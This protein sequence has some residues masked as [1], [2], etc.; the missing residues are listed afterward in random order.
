MRAG[1]QIAVLDK[2]DGL[3]HPFQRHEDAARPAQEDRNARH[4][5]QNE[6]AEHRAKRNL[7]GAFEGRLE[8]PD[9]EHADTL[10]AAIDDR[11]VGRDVPVIDDESARQPDLALL[12]HRLAHDRRDARA[13]RAAAFEQADIGAHA[14]IV[15]KQ[16]RGALASFRQTRLAVNEVVDRIDEFQVAIE[17][18]AA[19]QDPGTAAEIDRCRRMDNHAA[20]LA[21]ALGRH[22]VAGRDQIERGLPGKLRRDRAQFVA[23]EYVDRRLRHAGERLGDN[24]ARG[25]D[26]RMRA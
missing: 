5:R 1:A 23:I 17:Q 13:E 22:C 3:V 24:R 10:S 7:L 25:V 2:G 19:D 21:V 8:E 26:M 9:I 11:F 12:Q 14:H 20:R 4:R 6:G 18:Y 15:E 16:C